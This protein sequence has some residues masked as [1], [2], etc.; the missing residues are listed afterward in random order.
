MKELEGTMN[1]DELAENYANDYMAR[2]FTIKKINSS[3]K[4]D[5]SLFFLK[6][7]LIASIGN[8]PVFGSFSGFLNGFTREVPKKVPP[9]ANKDEKS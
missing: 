6:V 8:N 3:L 9:L 2:K 1:F 7:S 4:F 5:S